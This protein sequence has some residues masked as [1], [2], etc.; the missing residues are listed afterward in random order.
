MFDLLAGHLFFICFFGRIRNDA[1]P[2]LRAN[3]VLGC[4][5]PALVVWNRAQPQLEQNVFLELWQNSSQ[6]GLARREN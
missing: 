5:G 6:S 2:T 3:L 4:A 1:R